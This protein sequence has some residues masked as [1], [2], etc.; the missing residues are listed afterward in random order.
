MANARQIALRTRLRHTYWLTDCKPLGPV[1]VDTVRRKMALIDP[2][3]TLSEREFE[4]LLSDHYGFA[5]VV[6]ADGVFEGWSIPELAEARDTATASIS[7]MRERMSSI[8]RAGVQKRAEARSTGSAVPAP[9][10]STT[11]GGDDEF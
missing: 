4:E 7:A 2:A 1:T 3:D 11:A 10:P 8:A 6:D 5:K 9:A